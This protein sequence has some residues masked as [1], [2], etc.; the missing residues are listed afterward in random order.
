[1]EEKY[2]QAKAGLV[3]KL[4]PATPVASTCPAVAR[5]AP[6]PNN[7]KLPTITLPEFDGDFN[8]WLTFHDTFRSMIHSSTEISF[9]QKFH[10]LRASL[11][12]EAAN[13]IQSITITANNY[14]V[15]WDTLVQR[16]SNKALLRKK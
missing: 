8:N 7:V 16:Y 14:T 3:S 13:L 11:K 1:M 4:R 12:G 10:Y 2:F 6:G 5:E 15:A 9:V